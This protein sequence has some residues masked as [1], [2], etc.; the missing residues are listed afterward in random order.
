MYSKNHSLISSTNSSRDM[1][2]YQ[3]LFE[4]LSKKEWIEEQLSSTDSAFFEIIREEV[5]EFY[6]KVI[7]H[8]S[9][10]LSFDDM[11]NLAKQVTINQIQK[12]LSKHKKCFFENK[13]CINDTSMYYSRIKSRLVN[14]LHNLT[15][16]SRKINVL[17]VP[18]MIISDIYTNYEID[19]TVLDIE[20]IAIKEPLKLIYAL[21]LL[22]INYEVNVDEAI[23]ICHTYNIDLSNFPILDF[24][25]QLKNLRK[26][27]NNQIV[28]DFREVA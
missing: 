28:I 24:S 11:Y 19:F 21:N 12:N 16:T 1:D 2:K 6:Y 26:V 13:G 17:D 15:Q 18:Y 9:S 14:N 25:Y 27:S 10:I 3:F 22:L 7:K 8:N 20:K 5:E 4:N 23:D